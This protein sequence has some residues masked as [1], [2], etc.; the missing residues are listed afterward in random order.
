MEPVLWLLAELTHEPSVLELTTGLLWGQ[1]L[2]QLV[3]LALGP[4]VPPLGLF[5]QIILHLSEEPTLLGLFVEETLGLLEIAIL[6]LFVEETVGL[7]PEPQLGMFVKPSLELVGP[8]AG[9]FQEQTHWFLE[10]MILGLF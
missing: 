4:L 8:V 7:L 2:E 9:L 6:G 5:L 1:A 10:E 3:E